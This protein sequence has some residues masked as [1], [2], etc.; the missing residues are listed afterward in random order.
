MTHRTAPLD[1]FVP[2]SDICERFETVIDAPADLVMQVA[3]AFDMQSLPLVK[4]I[5][6]L[7]EKLMRATPTT[8]RRP[9]GIV[10]ETRALGWGL[11]A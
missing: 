4:A 6:R 8:P 2:H 5:F 1:R 7:R 3:T 11:L 9:Q 10:A